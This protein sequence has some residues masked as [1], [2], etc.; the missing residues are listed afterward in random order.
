MGIFEAV[1]VIAFQSLFFLQLMGQDRA[2]SRR[3]SVLYFANNHKEQRVWLMTLPIGSLLPSKAKEAKPAEAE[4][5]GSVKIVEEHF[6]LQAKQLVFASFC[7][8]LASNPSL[9]AV[10]CWSSYNVLMLHGQY[11]LSSF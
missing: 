10:C 8:R 4:A 6:V 2:Q 3:E 5:E 9:K 11:S 7:S 1:P